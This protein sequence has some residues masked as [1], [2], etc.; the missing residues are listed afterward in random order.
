MVPYNKLGIIANEDD[1][2]VVN[3][4][5]GMLSIPDRMQSEVS[6]KDVLL[7]KFG[8]IYTVHRLDKDTSGVIIF[9]KNKLAHEQLNKAFEQR[10]TTKLYN[11]LVLGVPPQPTGTV[12]AKI[13]EHPRKDGSMTTNERTGKEA[14]T[15]YELLKSF[16]KYSWLQFKILTGRTHQIRVHAKHIG[17]PIVCDAVYG[18]GKA[19]LISQLKRN[20]NL[21]KKEFEERPIL[22]RQALH[23]AHLSLQYNSQ[24]Y[25]FDAPLPKDLLALLKQLEKN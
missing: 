13:A 12:V 20:Y 19:V 18:D 9:A 23:A 4:P 14:I 1:F 25:F 15:E 7:E 8:E 5:A 10:Q 3:K 24:N 11:G 21:S 2:I 17:C 16:K 22:N 6:L